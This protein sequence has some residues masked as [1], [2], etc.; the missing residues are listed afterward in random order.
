MARPRTGRQSSAEYQR[1]YRERKKA[2]GAIAQTNWMLDV[3]LADAIRHE[4]KVRGLRESELATEILGEWYEARFGGRL[5]PAQ[6]EPPQD[7]AAPAPPPTPIN[8]TVELLLA[9]LEELGFIIPLQ[10]MATQCLHGDERNGLW[11]TVTLNGLDTIE[12]GLVERTDGFAQN[13]LHCVVDTV[14][15]RAWLTSDAYGELNQGRDIGTKIS[16]KGLQALDDVFARL[17]E[18]IM[19]KRK[20]LRYDETL[21][22]LPHYLDQEPS[23]SLLV[24]A[25]QRMGL[26]LVHVPPTD[27][28]ISAAEAPQNVALHD[29]NALAQYV[30]QEFL[31]MGKTVCTFP[32]WD[33]GEL[34]AYAPEAR[35]F[36]YAGLRMQPPD[37]PNTEEGQP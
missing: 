4:A 9:K 34:I 18:F 26:E 31:R 28:V 8:A 15:R 24:L 10:G 27:L 2:Q 11:A 37:A 35:A 6:P 22:A 32:L 13:I 1:R 14:T 20:P 21:A 30:R 12:F 7:T 29:L 33:G 36:V 19:A 3:R 5:P 16:T 17:R 25:F 23:R